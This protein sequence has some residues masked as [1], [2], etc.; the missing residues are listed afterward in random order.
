MAQL[1]DIK[2][3]HAGDVKNGWDC[4]GVLKPG[5]TSLDTAATKPTGVVVVQNRPGDEGVVVETP[6]SIVLPAGAGVLFG[7]G[8]VPAS[9][10]KMKN[11]TTMAMK[12]SKSNN[13][14]P[15]DEPSTSMTTLTIPSTRPVNLQI[16]GAGGLPTVDYRVFTEVVTGASSSCTTLATLFSCGGSVDAAG[17]GPAALTSTTATVAAAEREDVSDE[18]ETET[19]ELEEPMAVI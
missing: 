1:E 16:T 12:P 10:R 13:V 19:E 15:R 3:I 11:K 8:T 18:L 5:L 2:C 17:S 6:K 9:S 14:L 4:F 7:S